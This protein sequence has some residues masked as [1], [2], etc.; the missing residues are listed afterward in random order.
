MQVPKISILIPVYN[1]REGIQRTLSSLLNQTFTNFEV[2][3]VDD[4]STD[5][6]SQ[7]A[8]N[9]YPDAII[10]H[11]ENQGIAKALNKGLEYCRGKYI[12]R[13]DCYDIMYPDRLEKQYKA[14]EENPELGVIGGHVML[15]ESNGQDIGLVKYPTTTYQT[16]NNLLNKVP[17]ILHTATMIRGDLLLQV[18]GYDPFYNGREDFELWTRISLVANLTNIDAPVVRSLSTTFGLSFDGNYLDPL[19]DLALEERKERLIKGVQ[20]KNF[21]RRNQLAAQLELI[22]ASNPDKR[23][24]RI[25]KSRLY[26]RRATFLLRSGERRSRS[27]EDLASTAVFP[28]TYPEGWAGRSSSSLS[29]FVTRDV[30]GA[31]RRSSRE[32]SGL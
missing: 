22:R 19:F 28:E 9:T 3:I 2:V 32:G 10:I 8:R 4:G 1:A 17:A 26:Q 16:L 15:Y 5:D 24:I 31:K 7:I 25:A 23:Q 27:S 18:G 21:A 29:A 6:S 14:L 20:W 13:I 11:Q 12:A 30:I